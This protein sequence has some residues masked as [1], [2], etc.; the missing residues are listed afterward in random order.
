MI[1]AEPG[2]VKRR[3]FDRKDLPIPKQDMLVFGLLELIPPP[4][5]QVTLAPLPKEPVELLDRLA[6]A[7][8]EP[9]L[10]ND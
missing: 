1:K 6:S 2:P 10:A 9:E 7:I 8:E 4:H 5:R 3:P